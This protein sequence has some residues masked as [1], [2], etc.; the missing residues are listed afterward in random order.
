MNSDAKKCLASFWD[1][2]FSRRAVQFHLCNSTSSTIFIT[3]D[4]TSTDETYILQKTCWILIVLPFLKLTTS[5]SPWKLG[6]LGGYIKFGGGYR[7]NSHPSVG[8]QPSPPTPMEPIFEF[9][10]RADRGFAST[11]TFGGELGSSSQDG[12][13]ERGDVEVGM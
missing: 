10:D 11:Y 3:K 1:T 4:Q 13:S 5:K 9:P 6:D 2:S 7:C 12:R 8:H